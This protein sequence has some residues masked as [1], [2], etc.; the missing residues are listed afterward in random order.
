MADFQE[1]LEWIKRQK[2]II[3][4]LQARLKKLDLEHPLPDMVSFEDEYLITYSE[5]YTK[6]Y[7]KKLPPGNYLDDYINHLKD[8]IRAEGEQV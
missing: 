3:Q 5:E 6:L 8:A 1:A 7:G 4:G 2:P